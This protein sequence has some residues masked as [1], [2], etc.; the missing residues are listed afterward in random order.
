MARGCT[1]VM[2]LISLLLTVFLVGMQDG[3]CLDSKCFHLWI[4]CWPCLSVDNSMRD[5]TDRLSMRA[6]KCVCVWCC[7]D[8]QHMSGAESQA[9]LCS[10][11]LLRSKHGHTPWIKKH[12]IEVGG[13]TASY[14]ISVCRKKGLGSEVHMCDAHRG[15]VE[16]EA[17][18]IRDTISLQ[19]WNTAHGVD[20]VQTQACVCVVVYGLVRQG[21]QSIARVANFLKAYMFFKAQIL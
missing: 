11:T 4:C 17:G 6:I 9:F 3:P 14:T 19:F 16:L 5:C 20:A 21:M 7:S 8:C 10:E 1:L 13:I 15:Q 2:K 18:Q 12:I